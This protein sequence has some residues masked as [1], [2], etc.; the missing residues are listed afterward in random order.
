MEVSK[1][2]VPSLVECYCGKLGGIECCNCLLADQQMIKLYSAL[3]VGDCC[4]C[5]GVNVGTNTGRSKC[6]VGKSTR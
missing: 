3:V 2:V 6:G 4:Y 1:T 5:P